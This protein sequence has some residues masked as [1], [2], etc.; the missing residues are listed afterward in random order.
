M[1]LS[2]YE[3][4]NIGLSVLPVYKLNFFCWKVNLNIVLWSKIQD[5]DPPSL[6]LDPTT[7]DGKL[8]FRSAFYPLSKRPIQ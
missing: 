5:D 7:V 3:I 2:L 6:Y 1:Y 8:Y 4:M